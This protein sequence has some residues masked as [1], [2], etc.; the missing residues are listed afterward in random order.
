MSASVCWWQLLPQF[1]LVI[2][3]F[4]VTVKVSIPKSRELAM[5]MGKSESHPWK[6]KGVTKKDAQ[7]MQRVG[8][9]VEK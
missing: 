7:I 3:F 8:G 6:R 9:L 5:G 4:T 2:S 1:L